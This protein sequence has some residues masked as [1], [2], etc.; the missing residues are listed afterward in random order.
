MCTLWYVEVDDLGEITATERGR[1][2]MDGTIKTDYTVPR[3]LI[4]YM[5]EREGCRCGTAGS[6]S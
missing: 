5:A 1:G 3:F 6:Q 2:I 4:G